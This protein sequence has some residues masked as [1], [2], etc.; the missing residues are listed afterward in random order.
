[1]AIVTGGTDGLG[2][3][4]VSSY[5]VAERSKVRILVF[6]GQTPSR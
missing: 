2:K 6:C 3:A 4:I 1:M 5:A